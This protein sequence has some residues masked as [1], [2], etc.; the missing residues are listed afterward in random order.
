MVGFFFWFTS[1]TI[2][3]RDNFYYHVDV[4]STLH[5]EKIFAENKDVCI[6]SLPL[7]THN[8]TNNVCKVYSLVHKYKDVHLT[9]CSYQL[10]YFYQHPI[11]GG[12]CHQLEEQWSKRQIILWDSFWPTH[13]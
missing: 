4:V 1:T 7:F 3:R 2:T 12:T 5:K 9:T 10:N 8:S 6:V 11:I 13:R